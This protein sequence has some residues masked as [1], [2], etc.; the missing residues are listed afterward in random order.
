MYE[1]ALTKA[2]ENYVIKAW[3][4]YNEERKFLMRLKKIEDIEIGV[5][6]SSYDMT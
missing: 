6:M 2:Y 5:C 1:E 3:L 4:L